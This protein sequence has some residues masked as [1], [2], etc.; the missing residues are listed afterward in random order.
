MHGSLLSQRM[1]YLVDQVLHT[2]GAAVAPVHLSYWV[3]T[4]CWFVQLMSLPHMTMDYWALQRLSLA[5]A[6]GD[7]EMEED[8]LLWSQNAPAPMSSMD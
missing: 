6:S 8:S 3:L 7:L 5:A 2:T 1:H 4:L